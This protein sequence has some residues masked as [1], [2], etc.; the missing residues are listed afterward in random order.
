MARADD[1]KLSGWAIAETRLM[2]FPIR[3]EGVIS[4]LSRR[5]LDAWLFTMNRGSCRFFSQCINSCLGVWPFLLCSRMMAFS[6]RE[7]IGSRRYPAGIT[8]P[9][10]RPTRLSKT[11][12]SR[13]RATL[14]CCRAS[15]RIT[16]SGRCSWRSAPGLRCAYGQRRPGCR[17]GK[18]LPSWLHLRHWQRL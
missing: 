14:R 1:S 6:G 18:K 12:R 2:L 5:I 4:A 3:D 7:E 17:A 13:S 16:M 11:I 9:F 15:S 10:P 8:K